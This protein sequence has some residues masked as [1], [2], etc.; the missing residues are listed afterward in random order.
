M[1]YFTIVSDHFITSSARLL[2]SDQ[3]QLVG[4]FLSH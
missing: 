2:I 1:V 3:W 4:V